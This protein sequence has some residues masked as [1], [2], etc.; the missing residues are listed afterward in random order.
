[1]NRNM[2]PTCEKYEGLLDLK[3]A[4]WLTSEE[5]LELDQHLQSC[6]EC[7]EQARRAQSIAL[8]IAGTPLPATPVIDLQSLT[9]RASGLS[10]KSKE[11][12]GA[13]AWWS[14]VVWPV[15]IAACIAL[16]YSAVFR[17]PKVPHEY[18]VA[19]T[20]AE[21]G[22]AP[23]NLLTYNRALAMGGDALEAV[24]SNHD[25]R[26]PLYEPSSSKLAFT[27]VQ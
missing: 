27:A 8:L 5:S 3:A 4:G 6:A 16:M 18:A 15:S 1:M 20:A 23:P 9:G 12:E 13:K 26:I 19:P 2:K 21:L 14:R 10:I 11:E 25:R 17:S 7:Q 24:L 22:E